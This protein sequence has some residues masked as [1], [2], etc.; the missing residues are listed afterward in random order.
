MM[1]RRGVLLD[2]DGIINVPPPPK[3]RYILEP[4]E[5]HLMPGIAESIRSLNLKN[6]PVA[7]VTNQKCVATERL[8]AEGLE[9]IHARMA[10]LLRE[11]GA[12]VDAVYVCPHCEEDGCDCRKPL[13][14][15]LLRAI[16]DLDLV[17]AG[18]WLIGDQPRDIAAGRAAGCRTLHIHAEP[19]PEADEHLADTRR[20]PG[21]ILTHF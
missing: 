2:R 19:C 6:I 17:P 13:P 18:T 4:A 9:A 20:L 10:D 1:P 8:T 3:Q 11:S 15:M 12:R 14:G 7:V 5:F 21:W 16:T